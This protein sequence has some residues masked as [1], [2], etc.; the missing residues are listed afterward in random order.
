MV[1]SRRLVKVP[2]RLAIMAGFA[3]VCSLLAGGALAFTT[4]VQTYNASSALPIGT[5]VSL[6]P[7]SADTVVSAALTNVNQLFGVTVPSSNAPIS[8]TSG[9][10][11]QLEIA[12][13]GVEPVLVSDING[14]IYPG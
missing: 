9:T 10:G 8:L 13:G 14:A 5:V 7:N 1:R 3:C 2:N 4:I 11:T 6:D 12:T